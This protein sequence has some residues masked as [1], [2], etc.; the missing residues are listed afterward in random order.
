MTVSTTYE[1]VAGGAPETPFLEVPGAPWSP[2]AMSLTSSPAPVPA[3][4]PFL[5][6]HSVDGRSVRADEPALRQLLE[7]LY[8]G[9]FDEAVAD[10]A[11]E[12]ET[13]VAELG[14]GESEADQARAEQLLEAWVEPLRRESQAV[15]MRLADQLEA[16]DPMTVTPARLDEMFEQAQPTSGEHGPVFEGFLKSLVKKAK[17]L[18]KG[19]I[20]AAKKGIAAVG[21]ILPIGMILRKLA[22]LARPL[23]TR[24][25]RFALNKLPVEYRE[26]A[27]L[28]ARRFLGV[29]VSE[30]ERDDQE[31]LDQNDSEDE[32]EEWELEDE[33]A[34]EIPATA[35]VRQIQ[36]AFDAEAVGLVFAPSEQEQD[37]YLAEA[38]VASAAATTSPLS[39]L[40]AA[41]TRFVHGI[42]RLDEGEDPT[43]LVE[44]FLPAVLPALRLGLKLAGRPRVVRFLAQY[45][46]RLIAPY[47]GPTVTPGLSR[48]IVDAGLRAMTLET[49]DEAGSPGPAAEAFASLV[50]DTVAKVAQLDEADLEVE[51]LVEEAAYTG[52][53]EAAAAGFPAAV[54]SQRAEHAEAGRAGGSWVSMPR[55]GPWRYRKYSRVFNVVIHP[56]AARSIT[57]FGGRPLSAF[58][59]DGMG[60]SGPVRARVHLYQAGPGTTLS[61]I[62]R[63]ERGVPGLGYADARARSR[64]HP[65]TP[66]AAAALIGEPGL[67]REVSEAYADG[68]GPLAVGQRLY[69]LEVPNGPATPDATGTQAAGTQATGTQ[70]DDAAAPA[71]EPA[72][73]APAVTPAP[74]TSAAPRSSDASAVIDPAGGSVTVTLYASEADAQDIAARLRRREPIGATLAA[75]R[76]IYGPALGKAIAAARPGRVRLRSEDEDQVETEDFL[77]GRGF[78][79]PAYAVRRPVRR[80]V[81]ARRALLARRRRYPVARR[82]PRHLRRRLLVSWV[83]RALATHL[84]R[85]RDALLQAVDAPADGVTLVIRLQPPA[86]R[87]LLGAGHVRAAA[88][89]GPGQVSVEVTPG[90]PRA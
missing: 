32:W 14:L 31:D 25:L 5:N 51:S 65:L 77:R 9:E 39:E 85:A 29:T 2:P 70:G 46:G 64:L 26:P 69:F 28:L 68:T 50:E 30:S 58:L 7:D 62:A 71:S 38:A 90:P 12:A 48:A 35:D 17:S 49:A 80:T 27:K 67:G 23:L 34:D 21:K 88:A 66:M 42:A 24:V 8:D 72:S 22:A 82:R 15:L 4:S 3:E 79:R 59:R 13:Y 18:A 81:L 45:L 6:E 16:E 61:R 55:G 56:A 41:R 63:A 74:A 52:F 11:A 43:P 78:A 54:L 37:L 33:E 47:V 20:A 76:R 83:A 86:L 53:H 36:D 60:R 75:L 87:A 19:A 84:D 44:N 73:P 40:D 57:T 10:L 89:A 1:P